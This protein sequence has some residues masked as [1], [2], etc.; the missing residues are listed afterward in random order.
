MKRVCV[1]CGASPGRNPVHLDAARRAGQALAGRGLGLVYG[2][3][4]VGL[5]GAVADGALEAGGEV[6]G[7][8]PRALQLRELAHDRLTSLHVVGSM[9]ERK[10]R[11]AELADAFVALPGGLGTL[12]ELAEILTW[13]QLGL[14]AKPCGL[15]DVEGYY[16]PLIAFLD[17]AVAEGFVRSEH[18]RVIHVAPDFGALLDAFDRYEPPRV[19]RWID[20]RTS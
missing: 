16:A 9:H 2:G 19:E 15:L 20:D 12:E 13:A 11:M 5:M 10:A 18:R 14:H 7:V 3:G 6:I 8:I 4:S 1:F 17:H